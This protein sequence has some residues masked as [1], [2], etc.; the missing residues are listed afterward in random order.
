MRQ[1]R[2]TANLHGDEA[3]GRE[4]LLGLARLLCEQFQYDPGRDHII[5]VTVGSIST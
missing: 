5:L 2:L 4:L 3:V 1:V